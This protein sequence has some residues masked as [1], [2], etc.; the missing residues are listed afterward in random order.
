M[1]QFSVAFGNRA[2]EM[3]KESGNSPN[4]IAL[5]SEGRISHTTVRR[6]LLGYPCSSDLII[7]FAEAAGCTPEQRAEWADELLTLV[8]SRAAYRLQFARVIY[9]APCY[10]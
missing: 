7:E 6:M 2:Q 9:G 5:K 8:E 1:V 3:L 10:A 4:S